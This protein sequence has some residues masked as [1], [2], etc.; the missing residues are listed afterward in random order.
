M[1]KCN[2]DTK[3]LLVSQVRIKDSDKDESTNDIASLIKNRYKDQSG[4]ANKDKKNECSE[5]HEGLFVQMWIF[6]TARLF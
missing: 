6:R 3:I 5:S 1:R 2:S 4:T